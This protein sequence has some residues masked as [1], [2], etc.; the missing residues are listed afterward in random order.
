MA[1]PAGANGLGGFTSGGSGAGTSLGGINL[2]NLP[3]GASING[4][5]GSTSTH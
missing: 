4:G 5:N 2:N 3:G 1:L